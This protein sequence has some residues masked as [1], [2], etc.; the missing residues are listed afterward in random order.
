MTLDQHLEQ[1][2]AH[3]PALCG[4]SVQAVGDQ[5]FITDLAVAGPFADAIEGEIL[6]RVAAALAE[7][8]EERPE[9]G[10]LLRSRIFARTL[11]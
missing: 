4:F 5:L 7:L 2:F 6:E 3:D 11:H 1:L 8:L 9:S 10:E